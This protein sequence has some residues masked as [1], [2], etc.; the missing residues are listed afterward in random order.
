MGS[1]RK[2]W[3]SQSRQCRH[4][5]LCGCVRASHR[6]K[7]WQTM[8]NWSEGSPPL[9]RRA[10]NGE[11]EA[12]KGL[13]KK[14]LLKTHKQTHKPAGTEPTFTLRRAG[15]T[16]C[17][18]A[19]CRRGTVAEG[20][21]VLDFIWADSVFV[22]RISKL[23]RPIILGHPSNKKSFFSVVHRVVIEENLFSKSDYRSTWPTTH[24]FSL[25]F[26]HQRWT[27]HHTGYV[28]LQ[29]SSSFMVRGLALTGEF[30]DAP[31]RNSEIW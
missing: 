8:A 5:C 10:N 21:F 7:W 2:A 23:I 26:Q 3:P 17:G 22:I 29:C 25:A 6:G 14:S 27:Y 28:T 24:P 31:S 20:H 30:Y 16:A 4:V 19:L 1:L 18:G 13:R 11:L 9:P 15:D 12:W